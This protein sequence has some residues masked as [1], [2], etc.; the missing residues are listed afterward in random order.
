MGMKK[1]VVR[2]S[3][4]A[5]P[6]PQPRVGVRPAPSKRFQPSRP[7]EAPSSPAGL[8]VAIA[9][10]IVVVVILV[11]V[12]NRPAHPPS[13]PAA[14]RPVDSEE[15]G[16]KHWGELE[17][18]TMAEWMQEHN[19]DNKALQERQQRVRNFRSGA[20][21]TNQSQAPGTNAAR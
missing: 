9:L 4:T 18:R 16:Q 17:G 7:R 20:T 19:K 2:K 5:S 8:I 15:R 6:A 12:S 13:R 14:P 21:S 11:A 10:G 3:E 1:I